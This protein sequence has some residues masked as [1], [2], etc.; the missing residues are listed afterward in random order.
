MKPPSHS[1]PPCCS[2]RWPRCRAAGRPKWGRTFLLRSTLRAVLGGLPYL[3]RSHSLGRTL[4]IGGGCGL[5]PPLE[6]LAEAGDVAVADAVRD[7]GDGQTRGAQEFGGLFEAELLQVALEAQAVA[8]AEETGEIAGA[9]EGDLAVPPPS[10]A[11]GNACGRGD[12]RWRVGARRRG[13]SGSLC[14]SARRN[15]TASTWLRRGVLGG[16]GIAER[17]GFHEVLVLLARMR[18]RESSP[19][20]RARVR[21]AGR[22]RGEP[23]F[24][25]QGDGGEVDDGVVQLE[26]GVPKGGIVACRGPPWRAAGERS[27]K[28]LERSGAKAACVA[29]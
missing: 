21:R 8:L 22:S 4:P 9:G 23:S 20:T 27:R 29:A 1:S 11:A 17:D 7:A 14:C 5:K 25:Q 19:R 3:F 13:H 15:Q 10:D 26:V 24:A 18:R 6:V 12:G 28:W 2:R 16:G